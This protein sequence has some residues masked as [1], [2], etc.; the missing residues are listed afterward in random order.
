MSAEPFN[1]PPV[2]EEESGQKLLRFLER[3]L[4]LPS[5]L[6]H[7]WIRTGQIRLNGKRC[8]PFARVSAGDVARLPPFAGEL[9]NQTL[10]ED[11]PSAPL[12]PLIGEKNGILAFCKPAGLPVQPGTDHD[13]ALS[14]R[15]AAHYSDRPFKPAPC[16]RL[17][18][19]TSGVVL[20]GATYEALRSVQDALAAGEIR[21][22]YLAWVEGDWPRA[23]ARLLRDFLRREN[24]DGQTLTR[25]VAEDAP[26]AREAV[27]LVEPLERR[28]GKTL[29]RVRLLT[30]RTHQIRAQL[31]A[32]GY[33][34]CGD[35]K[36][37]KPGVLRL[38]ALRVVLP[39]GQEFV[40][41]PP[42][43]DE[44]EP[45]ELPPP[46]DDDAASPARIPIF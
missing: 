38:H 46:L 41:P 4:N 40:C 32:R 33:P 31:A 17:D 9:V 26:Y 45:N 43:E 34:V 24:R 42:W 5:N 27:A 22:E 3:R 13:D 19:D 44:W 16:H 8:K 21:K 6:L 14:A 35:G 29:L 18:R 23:D 12:P 36:Y 7:R 10:A 39:D 30:G 11:A 25:I 2:G 37:G 1:F 28:G 15:L 20:V